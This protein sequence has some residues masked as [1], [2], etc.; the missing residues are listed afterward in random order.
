MNW[1][2]EKEKNVY[3]ELI[4]KIDKFDPKVE[5]EDIRQFYQ[6]KHNQYSTDPFVS[7]R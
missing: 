1:F 3:D 7:I 5:P 4:S 6:N 2:Y